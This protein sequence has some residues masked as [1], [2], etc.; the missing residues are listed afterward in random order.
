M[1]YDH[2]AQFLNNVPYKDLYLGQKASLTRTLTLDDINLFARV[3]GDVNPAHLNPDYAALDI[4]HGIVGH[5]MWT[6]ALISTLLGTTLPG[7]GTIYLGQDLSFTRPVRLGDSV[8]ITITLSLKPED[9]D[10]VVIFDCLGLNQKGETVLRGIAKVLAPTESV[11]LARPIL[12]DI[13][14]FDQDHYHQ[15]LK[16]C[17]HLP[18]LRTAL[19][20][21]VSAHII[22]A[23]FDAVKENLI[24]PVLVGPQ[25]KI[26]AAANE[27]N[28]D[29]S[30][31]EV[32][33][34]PHS[35][36][37]ARRGVEMARLGQVSALMKG[38]LH[39]DEFLGAIL[40]SD[41]GLR[42]DKR[43]SHA[44]L[45]D[46]KSYPKPFIITDAAINIA[47]DLSIKADIVQ[48]AIDLWHIL[49]G[50]TYLAKGAV[51][52]AVETINPR[53]SATLD[54]SALC[55]MAERGQ[56]TGAII[57]GPL[58]FDNAIS[59]EAA[60]EKNIISDVA[61]QADIL[62]VPEIESG[63]MLAKQLSFLSHADAAGIVLGAR[64]PIIL[65]SRAD[66]L[67]SRLWSCALAVLL[68]QAQQ[69][70]NLS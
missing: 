32:M 4:F 62:I 8:T 18:A 45:M 48:N 24:I 40:A 53:M 34:T 43:L 1:S 52:A 63:N 54:A 61:G 70:S 68:N 27:A 42:T 23:A 31:W 6:A 57:D 25:H 36:E 9:Q 64:V 50:D 51:L 55:K 37:A 66:S 41:S 33:D 60:Q 11:S 10:K 59:L 12:P 19:I 26:I 44:Y 29:I 47:P 58:A 17:A 69:A 3:S 2:N 20:H 38:S 65:T 28:I 22:Q 46:V 21:P 5:G 14:I 56:I 49:Y 39:S 35:H 67:R 16:Q 7:P 30:A 15:H 13:E